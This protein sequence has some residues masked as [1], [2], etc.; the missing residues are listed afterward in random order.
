MEKYIIESV[1]VH[2]NW[3]IS[4]RIQGPKSLKFS[5]PRKTYFNLILFIGIHY[6]VTPHLMTYNLSLFLFKIIPYVIF[7]TFKFAAYF[8]T[9]SV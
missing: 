8:V 3:T 9:G 2:D 7:R 5:I 1:F 4:Q 6:L